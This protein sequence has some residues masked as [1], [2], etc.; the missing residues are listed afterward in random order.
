M[1]KILNKKMCKTYAQKIKQ[2]KR[3]A[4]LNQINTAISHHEKFKN[5]FFYQPPTTAR[6]RRSY[7]DYNSIAIQFVYDGKEYKYWCNVRCTCRYVEYHGHFIVG[8]E[9]KDIRAFKKICT[10]LENAIANYKGEK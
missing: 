7:E 4:L 2:E 9:T 3:I 5:V 8:N 6:G 10:E 1:S